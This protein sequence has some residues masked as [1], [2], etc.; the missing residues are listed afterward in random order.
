MREVDGF[1]S[2]IRPTN[3][4]KGSKLYG[5]VCLKRRKRRKILLQL[6]PVYTRGGGRIFP[7]SSRYKNPFTSFRVFGRGREGRKWA[8][9]AQKEREWAARLLGIWTRAGEEGWIAMMMMMGEKSLSPGLLFGLSESGYARTYGP[10]IF[11][12]RPTHFPG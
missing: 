9:S 12:F 4:P 1:P 8:S 2:S 5:Q 7:P 6:D 10:N 3:H 11:P